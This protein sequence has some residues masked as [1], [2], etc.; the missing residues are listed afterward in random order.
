[1]EETILPAL[2]CLAHPARYIKLRD[3]MP[4]GTHGI[5][6]VCSIGSFKFAAWNPSS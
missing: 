2:R 5:L 4:E 6:Q 3:A 1:M